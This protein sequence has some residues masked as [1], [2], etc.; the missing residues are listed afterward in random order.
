M[1]ERT[2]SQCDRTNETTEAKKA[3]TAAEISADLVALKRTQLA[4]TTA[5][6]NPTNNNADSCKVSARLNAH[7]I[8]YPVRTALQD[9]GCDNFDGSRPYRSKA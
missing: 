3:T 5:K 4:I 9:C 2:C 8:F 7:P 6:L 1:I